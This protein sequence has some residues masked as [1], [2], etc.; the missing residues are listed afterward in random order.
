MGMTATWWLGQERPVVKGTHKPGV[1]QRWTITVM[2]EGCNNIRQRWLLR[3]KDKLTLNDLDQY[4]N[5]E[6]MQ[7]GRE[8]DGFKELTWTAISR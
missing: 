2:A 7:F 5:D 6:I 8:N 3:P 4:I 1:P